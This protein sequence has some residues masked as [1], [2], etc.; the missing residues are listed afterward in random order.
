MDQIQDSRTNC[1]AHANDHRMTFEVHHEMTV[2]IQ[3]SCTVIQMS[4]NSLHPIGLFNRVKQSNKEGTH[5][6]IVGES[7]CLRRADGG[8]GSGIVHLW[9]SGQSRYLRRDGLGG[10]GIVHLWFGSRAVIGYL[11]RGGQGGSGI[12][13]LCFSE[14]NRTSRVVIRYRTKPVE[15]QIWLVWL[16]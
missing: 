15:V 7:P 16:V 11:R 13:H 4:R 10:S 14:W 12:V 9:I 5:E 1:C 6:I 8:G 2:R 3:L